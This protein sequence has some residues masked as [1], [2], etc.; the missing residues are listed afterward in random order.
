MGGRPKG[1]KNKI[2]TDLHALCAEV[3]IDPIKKL[4]EIS[5]DETDKPRQMEALKTVC[6]YIYPT[7]QSQ[8]V[9]AV[10]SA[11]VGEKFQE[12]EEMSREEQ[13]KLLEENL[14]ALKNDQ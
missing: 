1:S 4:L 13:I 6:K 14:Q 5:K 11:E 7:M 10:V 3:G 2:R 12:I 9:E 8:Q